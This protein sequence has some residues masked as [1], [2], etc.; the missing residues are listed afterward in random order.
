MLRLV[1]AG[2][3]A[4]W[5]GSQRRSERLPAGAHDV[6]NA[7]VDGRLEPSEGDSWVRV[8]DRAETSQTPPAGGVRST[9]AELAQ[10]QRVGGSA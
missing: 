6:L 2:L 5:V 8:V 10:I 4:V 9:A 3:G 7:I 1:V